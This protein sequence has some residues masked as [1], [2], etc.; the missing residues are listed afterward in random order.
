PRPSCSATWASPRPSP[1]SPSPPPT[2]WA[3]TWSARARP[4]TGKARSPASRRSSASP[5]SSPCSCRRSAAPGRS[6]SGSSPASSPLLARWPRRSCSATATRRPRPS[7]ASTPSCCSPPC[8]RGWRPC[9]STDRCG[10]AEEHLEQEDQQGGVGEA[11]DD[12][13]LVLVEDGAGAAGLGAEQAEGVELEDRRQEHHDAEERPPLARA[14]AVVER[15]EVAGGRHEEQHRDGE[16][17]VRAGCQQA[18]TA[19]AGG[20]RVGLAAGED[21]LGVGDDV[22]LRGPDDEPHVAEHHQR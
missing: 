6:S 7:A 13:V 14:G 11:G 18:A 3:P 4:M 5:C 10:L 21:V 17:R 16:Q 9:Y 12:R 20:R 15:G 1:C 19:E 8:G 2:T 22:F